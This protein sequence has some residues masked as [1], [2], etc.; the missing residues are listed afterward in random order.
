MD[1]PT[2]LSLLSRIRQE[3]EK[4]AQD[5]VEAMEQAVSGGLQSQALGNIG[6]VALF[7]AGIGGAARGAMGLYNVLKRNVVDPKP[8]RHV[9]MM[10][11]PIPDDV[12]NVEQEKRGGVMGFLFNN[13]GATSVEGLPYYR[14]AVMMGGLAAGY[15]GW[16]GVDAVLNQRRKADIDD[17][18]EQ[19]RS[20]FQQALLGQYKKPGQAKEAADAEM[21]KLAADL[22]ALYDLFEKQASFY[23]IPTNA[24]DFGQLAGSYGMYAAPSALI[25]GY[26]AYK[27]GDKRTRRDVL[28]KALK[29]RRARRQAVQ[30]AELYATP[31][32]MGDPN[33]PVMAGADDDA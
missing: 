1:R 13:P 5:P 7:S 15:G 28:E 31:V 20:E 9:A 26:A 12:E 29:L 23:G 14:P 18:V 2:A 30:P 21:V 27:A 24:E 19:A 17:D 4:T 32:R 22:D 10:P 6:K 25:A 11:L 16:K 33:T 8:T 3:A